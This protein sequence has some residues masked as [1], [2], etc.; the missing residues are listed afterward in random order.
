MGALAQPVTTAALRGG[1]PEQAPVRVS[2]D[3]MGLRDAVGLAVARHPDIGRAGA[4]VSQSEAEIVVAQSAWYPSVS[5]SGGP[6][7]G[8]NGNLNGNASASQLLYDFGKTPSS[9]A[10]AKA[11]SGQNRSNLESTMERI[12][13]ET[14]ESY[15]ELARSEAVIAAARR[16]VDALTETRSII[17]ERVQAGAADSSDQVLADVAIQRAQGDLLK[18][19]TQRDVAQRELMEVIGA[20]PRNVSS[21]AEIRQIE[22]RLAI[23]GDVDSAPAVRAAASAVDAARADVGLARAERYPS[24]G[25]EASYTAMTDDDDDDDFDDDN[26]NLWVGVTLRGNFSTGGLAKG[27]INAASAGQRAAEH[28][29]DSERLLARTA[30]VTAK[31]ESAGAA[32]RISNYQKMIELAKN[33][34]ELYWQEYTLNKRSLNDVLSTDRDV[35]LAESER[36]MA[37]S[38]GIKAWVR[39]A[40]ATGTLVKTLTSPNN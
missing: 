5:Y 6:G 4:I 16:Q 32:S 38:D 3:R 8:N 30:Q 14:A 22:R 33:A 2:L 1:A 18:S 11:E 12:A 9:I 35:F 19:M 23:E 13:E 10:K 28:A 27:R 21:L 29:L 37:E 31:V 25:A 34:R 7:Y 39:A 40:A 36:I 24:I 20:A 15:I 17:G 26:D